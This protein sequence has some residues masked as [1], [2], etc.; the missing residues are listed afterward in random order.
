MP[1]FITD[2]LGLCLAAVAIL[3]LLVAGLYTWREHLRDQA[4]M[5]DAVD[6]HAPLDR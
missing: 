6:F 4:A 1:H 2:N 5:E 3:G